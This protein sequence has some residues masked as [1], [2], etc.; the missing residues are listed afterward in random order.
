M[1]E[2]TPIDDIKILPHLTKRRDFLK[3][4][5]KLTSGAVLLG[6]AGKLLSATKS[7]SPEKNKSA[8]ADRLDASAPMI[9]EIDIIAFNYA[10]KGWAFC[11]GQILPINQN[12]ALFSILGTT[13]GGNGTQTFALPDLRGRVPMGF[14]NGHTLGERGGEQSHTLIINEMPQ[15]THLLSSSST[16]G[17]S[18]VP[19]NNFPAKNSVTTAQYGNG[20][21]VGMNPAS[22]TNI[23]GS[24]AHNNMMPYLTLNF[25]I[26][27]TG[28][29]PS[30]N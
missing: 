25:I 20:N 2:K 28:V 13:Y 7:F 3:N 24:L 17:D 12:Q 6:P 26:A 27:L 8:V 21:L 5:I 1:E 30:R 15:H 19:T 23:G 10:P 29:F 4:V 9:G 18:I 14:S 11:N 22:I 16:A